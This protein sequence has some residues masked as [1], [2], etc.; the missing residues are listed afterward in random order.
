[1]ERAERSGRHDRAG[2]NGPWAAKK[3]SAG[4]LFIV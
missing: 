4:A 3:L 1:L 2:C